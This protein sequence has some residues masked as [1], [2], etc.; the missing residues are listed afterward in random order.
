MPQYRQDLAAIHNNLGN[1]LRDLGKRADAATAYRDA[2]KIETQLAGD[3]S[4]AMQYRQDLGNSQNAVA[5]VFAEL[6]K[7]SEAEDAIREAVRIRKQLSK[8]A[9][10]F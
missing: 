2:L 1:L 4:T 8:P 3:L 9:K 5:V 6:G 7:H 10:V